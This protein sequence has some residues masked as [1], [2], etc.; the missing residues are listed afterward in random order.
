LPNPKRAL[1]PAGEPDHALR[2]AFWRTFS[3]LIPGDAAS[4]LRAQAGPSFARLAETRGDEHGSWRTVRR[5]RTR[6]TRHDADRALLEAVEAWARPY[7][8]HKND[9][10]LDYALTYLWRCWRKGVDVLPLADGV[11]VVAE[12]FADWTVPGPAPARETEAQ[13]MA[14][15]REYWSEAEADHRAAGFKEPA[16]HPHDLMHLCWLVKHQCMRLPYER[17]GTAET[18]NIASAVRKTAARLDLELRTARG[19]RKQK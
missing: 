18:S 8:L 9:W 7:S 4:K 13:W 5:L 12:Q 10:P 11:P 14:R 2:E 15:A 6:A 19:R 3:E 1:R 17:C 16:Y